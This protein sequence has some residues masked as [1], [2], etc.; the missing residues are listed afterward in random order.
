MLSATVLDKGE[1]NPLPAF[2]AQGVIWVLS[3]ILW[4]LRWKKKYNKLFFRGRD[5]NPARVWFVDEVAAKYPYDSF[6]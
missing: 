2:M 3:F 4:H 5:S 6:I 1:R